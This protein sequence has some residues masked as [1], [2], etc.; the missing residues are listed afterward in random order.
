MQDGCQEIYGAV[1]HNTMQGSEA[2]S[3]SRDLNSPF[4]ARFYGPQSQGQNCK[5]SCRT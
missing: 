3:K 1:L 4:L 2:R 5:Y